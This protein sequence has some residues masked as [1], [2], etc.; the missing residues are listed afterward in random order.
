ME[1]AREQTPPPLRCQCVLIND[2]CDPDWCGETTA[3]PDSPWCGNCDG[4]HPDKQNVDGI[5]V[6]AAFVLKAEGVEL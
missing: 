4:R 3:G 2:G 5:T 6:T 1:P